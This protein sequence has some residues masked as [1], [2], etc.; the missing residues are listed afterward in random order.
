M[1]NIE[2]V[3]LASG[4]SGNMTYIRVGST[5]ITIDAGI[6]CRAIE[7]ALDSIGVSPTQLDAVFITHEHSDH[8][9]GLPVFTKKHALP[10]HAAALT[11][12]NISCAGDCLVKHDPLYTVDIG[13][14]SVSSF[15]TPHDSLCS[16]G[17]IITA[18]NITDGDAPLK[19]GFATDLGYVSG[20]VEELLRECKYVVLESN[21]DRKMLETGPY[22]EYLKQR[23][24]APT[25]HLSNAD[26]A[27]CIQRL[28]SGNV[29]GIMLAHLSE[30]NNR[31]ELALIEATD[32][33]D[34]ASKYGTV[35]LKVAAKSEATRLC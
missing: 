4:S 28:V 17:Y 35:T 3:S 23:I 11:A 29:R 32:A 34:R 25:G 31:P 30:E 33:L 22:P 2:I 26:C 15:I 14:I 24:I 12:D 18:N 27:S 9:K 13:E 1:D 19:I 6:S 20:E 10:I 16:V 8:I 21:H 7:R 5:R